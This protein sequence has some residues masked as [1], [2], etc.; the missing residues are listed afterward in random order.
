MLMPS[1]TKA[2]CSISMLLGYPTSSPFPGPSPT[3]TDI[4]RKGVLAFADLTALPTT[5]G[6]YMSY[7]RY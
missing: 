6:N 4:G 5:P 3:T 2:V 7:G 1:M